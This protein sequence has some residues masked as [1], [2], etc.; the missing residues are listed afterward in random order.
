MTNVRSNSFLRSIEV[1]VLNTSSASKSPKQDSSQHKFSQSNLAK[2][3]LTKHD[4]RK[5]RGLA[6]SLKPVVTIGKNGIND[7]A[8]AQIDHSLEAHE[9]IKCSLLQTALT[10]ASEL[11]SH[12]ADQLGATVVQT[13]GNRCVFYRRSSRKNFDHIL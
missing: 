12:V 8:I 2:Q 3:N 5:L 11:A 9:L 6:N 4:L 10:D 1:P 13:I 7:A